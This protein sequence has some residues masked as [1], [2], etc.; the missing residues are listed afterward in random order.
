MAQGE[1][2][3]TW[4]KTKDGQQEQCRVHPHWVLSQDIAGIVVLDMRENPP[5]KSGPFAHWRLARSVCRRRAFHE[6][7]KALAG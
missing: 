5:A 6:K 3:L 7:M 4:K 2:R 1:I